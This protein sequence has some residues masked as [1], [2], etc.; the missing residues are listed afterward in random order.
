MSHYE[1]FHSKRDW[2]NPDVTS[3]NRELGEIAARLV[4]LGAEWHLAIEAVEA[5]G[6]LSA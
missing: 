6:S 2:E 4:E 1:Q 5:A 3:I